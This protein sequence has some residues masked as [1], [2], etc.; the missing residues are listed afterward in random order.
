MCEHRFVLSERKVRVE[1]EGE[2]RWG[3]L[4]GDSVVLDGGGSVERETV[5]FLAPVTPS[6]IIAVHLTYRSRVDEYRAR[7]PAAPSY[8]M[9]PPSALNGHGGVLRRPRGAR[10][11][12]YEGELAVVIGKRMKGVPIHRALEHVCGYANANDV[13]LHDFRH[14]DRGSMLRV[15]GQDGFLPVGPELVPASEFDPA[16]FELR[17][18]VNG[19]VVQHGGA[20]D[21]IWS[22]AYM[23]ADLCRLITLEPGDVLLTGTPANS[24]PMEPGD[25]VA[26][27]IDGLGRLENAVV[28]WDVDLSETGD[29]PAVS[30][31]TLHVALAI[32]EDEAE[33]ALERLEQGR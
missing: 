15:K 9:K 33:R 8:F 7:A 23:L 27:E 26:V 31:N 29:Q 14:A 22:V 13:G 30:A 11:L 12:N 25:V 6:K 3:H 2:A 32:P 16:S 1:L 18:S 5:R 21:L 10:F 24:R 19:E 17:T 4:E 28:D 20:D